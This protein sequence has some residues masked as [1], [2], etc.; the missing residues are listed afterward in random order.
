M[1]EQVC[2]YHAR[3]TIDQ[4]KQIVT[5]CAKSYVSQLKKESEERLKEEQA[6][7]VNTEAV[8]NTFRGF[9]NYFR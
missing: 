8:L 9:G 7:R 2:I 4:C 5:E 6:N 3:R 1:G